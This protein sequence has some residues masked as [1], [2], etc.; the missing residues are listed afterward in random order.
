MLQINAPHAILVE[1]DGRQLIEGLGQGIYLLGHDDA[2]WS[3]AV[4][5]QESVISL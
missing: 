2:I 3:S 4:E 1:W 5:I